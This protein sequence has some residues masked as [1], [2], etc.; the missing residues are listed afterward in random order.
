MSKYLFGVC[1]AC[2][3]SG[4]VAAGTKTW[5]FD[6]VAIGSVPTGWKCETMNKTNSLVTISVAA[7][8]TAPGAKAGNRV[9][10]VA[11]YD[12]GAAYADCHLCWTTNIAFE[13]GTIE[14]DSKAAVDPNGYGGG[15]AWRI[16]DK[17]NYYAVR[18]SAK[19]GNLNVFKIANGKRQRLGSGGKGTFALDK[20]HH[21][22]VVQSGSNISV[23]VDGKEIATAADTIITGAGG[24]G[25]FQRADATIC[26]WDNVSV[27]A[28]TVP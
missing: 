27:T 4:T 23:S 2:L 12:P 20:W 21:V 24:V 6:E 25:V 16:K 9:L 13:D 3:L 28:S 17:N 15:V 1:I 5:T 11:N 14:F 26:S 18:Y 8:A 22:K 7:D 10:K 19:E